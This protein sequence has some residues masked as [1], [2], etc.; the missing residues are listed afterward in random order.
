MG[1][2]YDTI[3]LSDNK[4][5]RSSFSTLTLRKKGKHKSSW[6]IQ[7]DL[8][9]TLSTIS[10]LNCDTK[11]TIE[12][13][14]QVGLFHGGKSLCQPQKT[15]EKLVNDKCECTVE[16]TLKF[17]IKVHNIP[18]CAKLCFVVCEVAKSSKGNKTKRM[19]ETSN[20]K[21]GRG[22]GENIICIGWFL[23]CVLQSDCLGK[24]NGV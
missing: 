2:D 13:G 9:I 24:Y 20:N 1:S 15:S 11:R 23:G 6:N 14:L 18:R 19:K 17:D 8:T 3:S 10:G 4:K 21:V 12:V 5:P 7:E 16:E 22:F